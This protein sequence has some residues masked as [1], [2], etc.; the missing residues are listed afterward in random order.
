LLLQYVLSIKIHRYNII[1][2]NL[3]SMVKT[4]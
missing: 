1:I 4:G 3:Y 2:L